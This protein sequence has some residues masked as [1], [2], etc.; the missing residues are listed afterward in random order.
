MK[1]VWLSLLLIAI[2]FAS[3]TFGVFEGM[4]AMPTG[5]IPAEMVNSGMIPPGMIPP[6][7]MNTGTPKTEEEEETTTTMQGFRSR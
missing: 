6:G 2:I 4:D 7:M 3:T 5:M 1:I